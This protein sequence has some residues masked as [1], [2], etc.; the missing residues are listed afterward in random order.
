MRVPLCMRFWSSGKNT[1]TQ[2]S[3]GKAYVLMRRMLFLSASASENSMVLTDIGAADCIYLCNLCRENLVIV[4]LTKHH[5][6]GIHPLDHCCS[7]Q[8]WLVNL[9][10]VSL[11][12]NLDDIRNDPVLLYVY[13]FVLLV[14]YRYDHLLIR[15]KSLWQNL[16]WSKCC[17]IQHCWMDKEKDKHQIGHKKA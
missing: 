10:Q 14:Q 15:H 16:P 11:L 7:S 13:G 5:T 12:W 4:M 6:I 17:I 1:R 2:Q 9:T 3:P 8:C